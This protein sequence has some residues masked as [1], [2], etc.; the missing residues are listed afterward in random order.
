MNTQGNPADE[1]AMAVRNVHSLF[2]QSF[3]AMSGN[4]RLPRWHPRAWS[5]H[6]RLA[7]LDVAKSWTSRR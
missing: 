3:F 7:V 4:A 2:A 5:A 1:I 6:P